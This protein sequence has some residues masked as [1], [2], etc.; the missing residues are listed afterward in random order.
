METSRIDEL[1]EGLDTPVFRMDGYDDCVVGLAKW[2][3]Q[4]PFLVYDREKVIGKLMKTSEMEREDAIEFH[5]FNQAQAYL[6]EGTP[7][8][9]E[10]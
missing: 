9:L 8:F 1:V 7:A 4:P 5:E 6:G 2:H 3:T 10:T